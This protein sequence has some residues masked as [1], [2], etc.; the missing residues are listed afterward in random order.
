[1]IL[2][3]LFAKRGREWTWEFR[4][5]GGFLATDNREAREFVNFEWL[6]HLGDCQIYSEKDIT[7][8]RLK[9]K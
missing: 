9:L 5:S 4:L 2:F 7:N 1:M 3:F 6:K 8:D